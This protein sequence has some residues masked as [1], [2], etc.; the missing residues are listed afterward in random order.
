MEFSYLFDHFYQI[1][2][3]GCETAP[4]SHIH[5]IASDTSDTSPLITTQ[6]KITQQLQSPTDITTN[7]LTTLHQQQQHQHQHQHHTLHQTERCLTLLTNRHIILL[8]AM[9]TH[10]TLCRI[11]IGYRWYWRGRRRRRGDGG[12]GGRRR[13]R[14]CG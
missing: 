6:H 11:T 2:S 3:H 7:S 5:Y 8:T 12:R 10:I 4:L 9:L 13:R 1:T 14:G